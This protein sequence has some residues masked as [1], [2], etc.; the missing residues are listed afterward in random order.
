MNWRKNIGSYKCH[1]HCIKSPLSRNGCSAMH[2]SVTSQKSRE[3]VF[4]KANKAL[5]YYFFVHEICNEPKCASKSNIAKTSPDISLYLELHALN[6]SKHH[7]W[8]AVSCK[9]I[10][11]FNPTP[12]TLSF[13]VKWSHY[14]VLY[15]RYQRY[16]RYWGANILLHIPTFSYKIS[17]SLFG[18]NSNTLNVKASSL[19]L[20]KL[21]VS[22]ERKN[23]LGLSLPY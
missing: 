8:S 12:S 21:S 7:P 9:M 10:I 11:E 13:Q 19:K 1:F 2:W 23:K 3:K 17:L 14:K 5:L 16:Q 18:T 4:L 15:Q 6:M 22:Q 20:V